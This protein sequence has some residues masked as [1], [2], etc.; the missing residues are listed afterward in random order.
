MHMHCIDDV[1][2]EWPQ[3]TL[4]ETLPCWS[5]Q[6]RPPRPLPEL[7]LCKEVRSRIPQH[8]RHWYMVREWPQQ[9]RTFHW[10][11]DFSWGF[12]P[13]WC[14]LHSPAHLPLWLSGRCRTLYVEKSPQSYVKLLLATLSRGSASCTGGHWSIL[15]HYENTVLP[16]QHTFAIMDFQFLKESLVH[17]PQNTSHVWQQEF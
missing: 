10:F 17:W 8:H 2:S 6:H 3:V 15:T 4:G 12:T 1:Y 7:Y 9:R 16:S 14:C 13:S 5:A 11:S